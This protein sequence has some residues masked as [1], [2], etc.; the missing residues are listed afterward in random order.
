MKII[1]KIIKGYKSIDTTKLQNEKVKGSINDQQNSLDINA[2]FIIK[3]RQKILD[4]ISFAKIIS[5]YGVIVLHLN[6]F[7]TFNLKKKKSWIKENIYETI[8]YYSVPFF[9]LC[10]GATLLDFQERYG[11]LEYNKRRIVKVFIPLLGWT[12]TL[13]LI[14]VYIL[15]NIPK[16]NLNFSSIWNY[17]FKSEMYKTFNSLHIFLLTYI[18]IPLLAH[19]EKANKI[20]IYSY[21]FFLLFITQAIIPY[22]ISLF[23]NKIIWIYNLNIG[24]I[25]YI[26]GG[27]I[28]QNYSFTK[29]TKII[30]Y[31][32]GA[33][34][35]IIHLMGT[36][37]LTFKYHK[38][39]R[40]HKG[41]L[42]APC[43]IYSCALFLFVKEY[44]F[45]ITKIINQK[46]INKIGS[47]T[48][49]PFF[50]HLTLREVIEKFARFKKLMSL[51]LLLY[52]F[53][54]FSICIIISY[55]LKK[56]PLLKL[57]VP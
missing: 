4:Y 38:I 27:Y 39:I 8:F 57:L 30:I 25:V 33:F 19:V 40:L 29:F 55:I 17:F 15:K 32:L 2:K 56:I 3:N 53:V 26:F 46:Y 28:I 20:R 7:W 10:I 22:I 45:I 36:Q 18:L 24:Y 35:F 13:Y 48:L 42:N 50:I 1:N 41:Y 47:L 37:V 52:S 23:G 9:V 51:N 34:S 54:N 43:I 44:F 14:K 5:S 6:H 11:L 16:I 12:L 31:I 21:Y 49:G